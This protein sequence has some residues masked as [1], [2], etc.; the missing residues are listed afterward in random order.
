MASDV[1]ELF[2]PAVAAWF[3]KA[4]PAGPTAPQIQGWPPIARGEN[5]LLLSPTGSGKTLAA[6]LV[7]LD[8]LVR[9]AETAPDGPPGVHTLYISPLKALNHD[10]HR[11]LEVPLGG[12]AETARELGL[13]PPYIRTAVRTGDTPQAARQ[14]MAKDP[15]HVLIT[16]PESLYVLLTSGT[17]RE[18]MRNVRH[19]IVDE[20]HAVA[21]G[22]RGVHL[23]LSLER[24]CEI[25]EREP[26]RVG[27]SATQ[28][29]LSEIARFLGG[30]REGAPRPVTIVEAHRPKVYDLLVSAPVPDMTELPEGTIWPGLFDRLFA[31]VKA[32]RT[33]LVFANNRRLA[34]RVAARLA[35]MAEAAGVEDAP[36]FAKAHHGSM[37]KERRKEIEEALKAGKLRCLVATSSLELGI[38]VG[39]IDLV[40]LLQSPGSVAR[41]LQRVGRSGH[42]VGE[43]SRG[44][45]LPTHRE[46]LLESAVVAARSLEGDVESTTVPQNALDV[47]AQ[48]IVASVVAEERTAD[49]LFALARRAYPY[50]ALP[51][52]T[53]D[54]VLEMLAGRYPAEAFR[55]L[56]PRL[57][58][59]RAT[60]VL[61]PLPGARLVALASG[62][63]IPDRGLYGVYLED[64][65][66]KIGELDEEFVYE[67]RVGDAFLLGSSAWR[68]LSI[69]KDRVVV[70]AAVGSELPK[71][72]FWR[73]EATHRPYALALAVGAFKREAAALLDDPRGEEKLAETAPLDAAAAWNVLEHLR[74][75][76][77]ST[78]VVPDDATIV[79]ERFRDEVGDP[80]LVVHASFGGRV[81]TALALALARRV[82][83][84]TGILPQVV[85]G[86]AGILLRMPDPEVD[87]PRGLLDGLGE[88]ET[89]RAFLEELPASPLFQARFREAAERALVLPRSPGKRRPFWLQRL[90]ARD[91]QQA[92]RPFPE[93][94]LTVE[95]YRDAV[96]EHLDLDGLRSALA[97]MRA[98]EVR[99]V[100]VDTDSPSPFAASLM[101]QFVGAYLYEPDHA[102]GKGAVYA[103]LGTDTIRAV[104]GTAASVGRLRPE[105]IA[106]LEDDL[107]ATAAARRAKSAGDLAFL[108][109]RLGP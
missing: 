32:H 79:E 38:D 33:T 28:R 102:V 21:G 94:P 60:G 97:A 16:T 26:T 39:S 27:L 67:S 24:L 108:L 37:A 42:M 59:N 41:C 71:M 50:H 18:A 81:N 45:F 6:F 17:G 92:M 15:P 5:T 61:S 74:E 48:Q 11:N 3:R 103:A 80:R 91:L 9:G 75:Q 4:F 2:H 34:E 77:E 83:D 106:E 88:A 65:R 63:V 69:D 10:I 49:S 76:R 52:S 35:D 109:E 1:L 78:G 96:R 36:S 99:T 46:D 93:F 54:E 58:W 20:I 44:R 90:R 104:L 85:A 72:P 66:T 64:A 12:I 43:V 68:I 86:D 55:A 98:G 73:G 82:R 95:A 62:G 40:V 30:A 107:Q 105:A 14:K 47:L 89:E 56:R 25:T 7:A 19:V 101:F 53:F 100:S 87:F 13:E 8:E 70:A 29:P 51:R 22:K 23:A 84:A 31:Y 57:A